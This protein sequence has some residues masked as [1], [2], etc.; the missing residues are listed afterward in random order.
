MSVRHRSI[1]GSPERT[2]TMTASVIVDLITATLA[3]ATAI[4]Q[5]NVASE[6]RAAVPALRTLIAAKHLAD[7]PVVL[8]AHPL[9]LEV[10]VVSGAKA[11]GM[12]EQLGKVPGAATASTWTVHLPA[13][14]TIGSWVDNAVAGLEHVTTDPAPAP[15]K[16]TASASNGQLLVDLDALRAVGGG[17]RR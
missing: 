4:D 12:T 2:A 5:D 17:D 9:R 7:D 11:I 1:A 3:P 6:L 8:V 13:G 15:T 16:D 10:R 14:A